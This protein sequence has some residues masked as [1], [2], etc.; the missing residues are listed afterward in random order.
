MIYELIQNAN[1]EFAQNGRSEA[2]IDM[3]N[4]VIGSGKPANIYFFAR[5]VKG[6]DINKIQDVIINIAPADVKYYFYQYVQG[7]EFKSFLIDAL[8]HKDKFWIEK[9]IN[10][11]IEDYL[12]Q[13]PK[14]ISK[15][16][17]ENFNSAIKDTEYKELFDGYQCSSKY[18]GKSF[19]GGFDLN[20]AIEIAQK[21]EQ[22]KGR[23]PVFIYLEKNALHSAGN[24]GGLLF[25]ENTHLANVR[26][27]ERVALLRGD[28]FY[29]FLLATRCKN[30]NVDLMIKGLELAKLDYVAIQKSLEEQNKRKEELKEMIE[31]TTDKVR[32]KQYITAY[33][34]I[35]HISNYI[36]Q[37]DNNYIPG[38]QYCANQNRG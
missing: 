11:I 4:E 31:K 22:T 3:E 27:F 32:R 34:Q 20:R 10:I 9:Y 17:E 8:K 7:A 33:N 15:S 23:S 14:D 12:K 35:S 16:R 30:V 21:E 2:F 18:H 37:I 38:L 19:R 36:I 13:A 29:M 5:Y 28:P 1:A 24:A 25:V 26:A 6:A